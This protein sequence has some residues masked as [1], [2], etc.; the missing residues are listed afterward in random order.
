MS[1]LKKEKNMLEIRPYPYAELSQMM[2]TH[3]PEGIRR[4]LERWGVAFTEDGRK[5]QITYNIEKISDPF[6]VYCMLDLNY[7]PQTNFTKL[8]YFFYYFLNDDDFQRLPDER[9]EVLMRE[10][11]HPVSRQTIANY[12]R[13]LEDI[14]LIS[15]N[16]GDYHYYFA[17]KANL[18]EATREE[19]S[20][21]WREYWQAKA[22]GCP[23]REAIS[24]MCYQHGGIARKQAIVDLNGIY[25]NTFNDINNMVCQRI[26]AEIDN[27][28]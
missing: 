7:A 22:E 10:R 2:G 28:G 4:R 24:T 27:N 19:Y 9:L 25:M 3:D 20:R 11:D 16:G 23:S 21:A 6:K 12:F 26:Q 14:D 5:P 13:R 1:D 15:R 18:R 8:A 17:R